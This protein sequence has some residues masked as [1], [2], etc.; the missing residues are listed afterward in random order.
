MTISL[1]SYHFKIIRRMTRM[2]INIKVNKTTEKVLIKRDRLF[3]CIFFH[4]DYFYK[5][6]ELFFH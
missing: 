4:G 6:Q 1:K 5:C 2:T 3:F